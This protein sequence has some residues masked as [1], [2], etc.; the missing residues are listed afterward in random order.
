M[1]VQSEL[2][3]FPHMRPQAKEW[4][5]ALASIY[6]FDIEPHLKVGLFLFFSLRTSSDSTSMCRAEPNEIDKGTQSLARS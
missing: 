6:Y 5:E 4:L 1:G 2:L 3:L